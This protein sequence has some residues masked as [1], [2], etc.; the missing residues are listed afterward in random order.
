MHTNE[1]HRNK[2]KRKQRK[3]ML[4]NQLMVVAINR[5]AV[6]AVPKCTL[7]R[8][9]ERLAL[10]D[11]RAFSSPLPLVTKHDFPRSQ[12]FWRL[13][14]V[15]FTRE[16]SNNFVP[17][18]DYKSLSILIIYGLGRNNSLYWK[19]FFVFALKFPLFLKLFFHFCSLKK[20]F[21]ETFEE[22]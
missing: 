17:C 16:K 11:I 10:Q 9:I 7:A 18:F 22:D 12:K 15:H 6:V 4:T 1:I 20:I 5:E 8:C 21:S 2:L 3:A 14:Y 13:F 19:F